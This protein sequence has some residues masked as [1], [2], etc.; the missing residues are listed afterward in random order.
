MLMPKRS[1]APSFATLDAAL[2]HIIVS[3]RTRQHH[4]QLSLARAA[5]LEP[6]YVSAYECCRRTFGLASLV[7]VA[8]ALGMP[9]SSL[10]AKA[11]GMVS[12]DA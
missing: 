2:R 5:K 10:V 9:L 6:S 11:E 8:R 3:E 12:D 1:P 7:R 4:S